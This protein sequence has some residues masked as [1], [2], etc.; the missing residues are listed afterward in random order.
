MPALHRRPG[1][2]HALRDCWLRGPREHDEI[3][4]QTLNKSLEDGEE[5]EEEEEAKPI[6]R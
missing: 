4:H 1:R 5:K 2:R 3:I 6:G